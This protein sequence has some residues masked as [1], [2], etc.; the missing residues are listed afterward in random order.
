MT[1]KRIRV[2]LADDHAL[3]RQGFRRILEDE[4]DIVVAGEA[5]GGAEAIELERTLSPDVVVMDL[6]MPEING[7]HAAIEILRRR[8]DCRVLMLSMH[9]DPQYVRNALDAGVKGY[10]L[11]NA[12]ETDLT[13]AVRVLASGGQFLS[14]ELSG[15]AIRSLRGDG[16]TDDAYSQL[17][18]REIQV[19][20]LIALGK[21]NKEIASILGLSANTIAV[22][23]TNLM[24]TLGVHKT[25]ELVLLAVKKGLVESQ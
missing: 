8:P 5:S 11:K 10:I 14:P 9:A 6:A 24:N 19:L 18:A 3:V 2:L 23:R 13:R 12:L 4:P 21:S 17:S 22:H 1:A 25:A 16:G 7:L 15:L 20:R